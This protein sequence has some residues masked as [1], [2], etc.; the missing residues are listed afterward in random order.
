M[1][2]VTT[3]L[4]AYMARGRQ[5]ANLR[6]LVGFVAV[7]AAIVV[8]FSVVFHVLMAREGQ[9]HSWL[10]GFYWTIVAMST[11][12]FGD[13]TFT[14]D[15]GRMF[16]VLVVVTG[17]V[18]MLVILP[19]TFIQ[20]FYAPWLE[21]RDQARA[22]RQLPPSTRGHVLLTGHGPVDRSLMQRLRQFRTPFTVIVPDLA[23]ALALDAEGVP[24]ML[25]D[26]DDPDTYAQARIEHAALL[27][28]TLSDPVNANI[29][30]T[31]R[32][33]SATVPIVALAS[34]AASIDILQLAG[35]ERVVHL[36]EL[37]GLAL[38]RRVFGRDGRSHVI[39]Q[40]D[41]LAIAE[42]AA[43]GT[44]LVGQTVR[45][46]GLR[47]RFNLNVAGVWERG[48]FTL[49]RPDIQV[50]PNTVLLLAGSPADLD[51]YD[52]ALAVP[53]RTTTTAV[54]IGGGRVGRAT[55]H[56]LADRGVDYRIVEQVA[57]RSRDPE[58]T[59][60]GD[61]ADLDVLNDAGIRDTT[62]VA[63]TTH[64][65]AVNIY[66]TL[67][68]RRLRPDMLILSRATLERNA[69]T[70]HRAG[71]DFVF[72][73]ASMGANAIFNALRGQRMLLVAEGLDVFKTPVPKSLVGRT[74]ADSRLRQLTGCNVLAIRAGRP[75]SG[76][77]DVSMPLPG[78]AELILIG[79]R[80]AEDR[81]FERYAV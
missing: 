56:A 58:R 12:G 78:D 61:A 3:L 8:L 62:C 32:E 43:A 54:I 73:Y 52:A 10:T 42:A 45:E 28:V 71:A 72:S 70:L 49:G 69:S 24:V 66:L 48:R 37:M 6:V 7:L 11:L 19:F 26:L 55:A 14:S 65:D 18:L 29:A 15:L 81:F 17:T 47:E 80:E 57:G 31:A 59:V 76:R 16:S 27:A 67:Y 75:V 22:P 30:A 74:L 20:F 51:A 33:R 25:G 60:V 34:S 68:C 39:G 35:C 1:R 4:S 63:V 38:A 23:E 40:V 2:L 64:E 44:P 21:A 46:T 53:S 9:D 41:E 79:D 50:T 77:V 13:V 5:Q 36:S